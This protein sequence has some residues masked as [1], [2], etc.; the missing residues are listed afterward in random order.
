MGSLFQKNTESQVEWWFARIAGRIEFRRWRQRYRSYELE[1]G[2][3]IGDCRI[4]GHIFQ[5]GRPFAPVVVEIRKRFAVGRCF[6]IACLPVRVQPGWAV[7]AV[8]IGRWCRVVRMIR[9]LQQY[10]GP[11]RKLHRHEAGLHREIE[12][13]DNKRAQE[14]SS[15]G[16]VSSSISGQKSQC[17]VLPVSADRPTLTILIPGGNC[18]CYLFHSPRF[19]TK[20]FVRESVYLAETNPSRYPTDL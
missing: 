20:S 17:S 14:E 8:M 15:P 18:V 10:D 12:P 16:G 5:L 3:Y 4:C 2:R 13:R 9:M 19:T 6:R 1:W 7:I 11:R